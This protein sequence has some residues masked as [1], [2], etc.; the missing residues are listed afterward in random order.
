MS[1]E[2]ELVIHLWEAVRDHVP[3]P[4]RGDIAQEMLYAL[5]DFGFTAVDLA[6]IVDED[7]DLN[8]AYDEVFEPLEEDDDDEK[9][10]DD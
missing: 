4:K 6:A 3:A 7:P 10:E 8:D 1:S 9:F 5:A 2:A